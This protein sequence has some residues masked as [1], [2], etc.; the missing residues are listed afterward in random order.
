MKTRS[1]KPARSHA[2]LWIIVVAA[3]ALEAISCTM[4]FTSRAAIRT[5]AQQRAE[6]E[7]R[8][9]ELEIELHTIEME[10]VA[11]ALSIFLQKHLDQPEAAYA[12]TRL[13]VR[14]LRENTSLAV[15]FVP[16]YYPSK[17]TYYEICSSRFSE[18]SI[19]TRNIGSAEHDYT[20]MEWYQNGFVHDSCWWCEPYLD[21]SGSETFVVSCSYPVYDKQGRVVAVVCV[22]LSLAYLKELSENLQVYPNSVSTIRSS[23]GRD[24]V[25]EQDTVVGK[26]YN[27][28]HEEIDA[29]G[30][31]IEI[32]IPEE[33]LFRNLNHIGRI[34][35][36][37]MLF[38]LGMLILIVWYAGRNSKQLIES[39]ARNQSMEN[40]LN[41]ARK[42]Q[43]AMLP[44]HFP[45]LPE[46]PN[47]NAYGLVVPAKE[48]GG[49]LFDYCIRNNRL[50]FCV[51]DVSGK[52]V[53]ASLVMAMTR[54]L[55]RSYLAYKDRPA[56]VMTLMNNSLT[57][58][59]NMQNMFVT[60]FIG[61]LD[62]ADGHLIYCNGGHDAPIQIKREAS[63]DIKQ[64]QTSNIVLPCKANLPVGVIA[65]FAYEEQE[66][67]LDEG[68][69]LFLYTDG[70]TE[71]ENK[72]HQLFGEQRIME[73]LQSA[74]DKLPEVL[75]KDM[76]VAVEKFVGEAEQSDD[77]TMFAIRFMP[78]E[79]SSQQSAV[80]HSDSEVSHH[81]LV[82]RNDIE[83]IPTLAEWIDSLGIP[84]E[85]NMPINLAI[86]EAVSNV[87]LY[88][89]PDNKSGQVLV[90]FEGCKHTDK[91]ER[92]TFV[93]SD[94]GIPFD[95]TQKPEAD[96]T[97]SAEDRAIGGLGIHLVRQIMDQVSYARKN[98]KNILTL[99]K[100]AK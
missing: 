19:Y 95:P 47:L 75:I 15:A 41:I 76:Q 20:Q 63:N 35:G 9:A 64:A 65:D 66:A 87:M 18:D 74:G 44:T 36:L 6:T 72:D 58:E 60:L 16:N 90:E 5:E 22:D 21:D 50:F 51:G 13:A 25:P 78:S 54:S 3:I 45:P 28:F 69:T 17:G 52:G 11:K 59:Q 73:Q 93:I 30:W 48:V 2:G 57:G 61:V 84:E 81:S 14:S 85:L 40:E 4:Y 34:V 86:E 80:S 1:N 23:Q 8:K 31:H 42:I 79:D 97:L 94:S 70:L 82:M 32:R 39:M 83:Q 53:P 56:E 77:L 67:T 89:Y 27:L 71:A 62:L 98:N 24:I 96:I 29:T 12:A 38:G 100:Y 7:L 37:L 46:Y 99:V 26:K 55:F 33:E 92:L 43:M 68:D 49:D 88:A 10:T 91:G